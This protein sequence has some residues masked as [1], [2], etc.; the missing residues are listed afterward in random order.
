MKSILASG[1]VIT[2]GTLSRLV[3]SDLGN[4]PFR[5]WIIEQLVKGGLAK[6]LPP[7][8]PTQ[9]NLGCL[10]SHPSGPGPLAFPCPRQG[11]CF[12]TTAVL[13]D[14]RSAQ[15]DE[16][17]VAALREM[18]VT[19]TLDGREANDRLRTMGLLMESP[20]AREGKKPRGPKICFDFQKGSCTRGDKCR[21]SHGSND[22]G[23]S[24]SSGPALPNSAGAKG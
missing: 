1:S 12:C 13:V 22:S 20:R 24:S 16:R 7:A 4:A 11:K 23:H 2:A 14:T 10:G 9:R 5:F 6:Q 15:F 19:T 21:F 8:V 18:G 17:L 3:N